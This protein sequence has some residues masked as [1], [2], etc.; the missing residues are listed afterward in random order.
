MTSELLANAY[1]FEA[2]HQMH[3]QQVAEGRTSGQIQSEALAHYTKLNLSRTNRILKT[4]ELLPDVVAIVRQIDRPM[5]WL[6]IDETWCGDAAQSVPVLVRLAALNPLISL[7]LILRDQ[8]PTVMDQFLTNGA[9]SIPKVIVLDESLTVLADWGP[10]PAALQA[11]VMADRMAGIPSEVWHEK[12]QL[13]YAHD[14]TISIQREFSN[15]L[16]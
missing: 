16:R 8:H 15:L 10:R 9:R 11:Q 6:V 1:D 2:W 14:H 3:T 7:R 5:T 4:T 12:I 13:W